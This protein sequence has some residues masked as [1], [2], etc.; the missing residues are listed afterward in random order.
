MC[1]NDE[2]RVISDKVAEFVNKQELFTSVD[3]AN[4]IKKDGTWI[5]N[6]EVAGW[7]RNFF[8]DPSYSR[9]LIPVDYGRNEAT[10]YHPG[11][12]D[13]KDYKNYDAKAISPEV[14]N[15]KY[16][17]NAVTAV[18]EEI[19]ADDT[20]DDDVPVDNNAPKVASTLINI[21]KGE[22][23]QT[24]LDRSKPLQPVIDRMMGHW[25][26]DLFTRKPGPAYADDGVFQGTD[27]DLACF[28]F[29]LVE[30][31]AVINI[32]KYK[33]RRATQHTEGQHVVSK[34]NRHGKLNGINANKETFS[35][36]I[37][38]F[39]MNVMM[40]DSVGY[41]RN[42][43]LVD[44][45]GT[46]YEGWKTLDFLP[47][48]KENDF[49]TNND[50]LSD[51]KISF[52]NFVHPNRWVSLYGQYY[53]ITKVL[54]E[55]MTDEA[56]YLKDMA[57]AMRAR[58]IIIGGGNEKKEWPQKETVGAQKSIIVKAFEAEV[59]H[60]EYSGQ[61][62][63][64]SEI[65]AFLPNYKGTTDG[66]LLKAIEDRAREFTYNLIQRLRFATRSTEYAFF[67]NGDDGNKIPAWIRN[68]NWERDIV[69]PRKK[70]KWSQLTLTDEVVI[71]YRVY[72]KSER[73]SADD[74]TD[75]G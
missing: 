61:F 48:A 52:K 30:R 45:D 15:D 58:G 64:E 34:D 53:Y 29:A 71:R 59:D 49:I 32:P 27:L 19:A 18:S 13:T 73:V 24:I 42:F 37:R 68:I 35:F 3:V 33:G 56:K 65:A 70:K 23:M 10:L 50:L 36:S 39:D 54:L 40:T 9:T 22:E 8:S 69:L 25:T 55:R 60:P 14:F 26:Y 17:D 67:T 7:L 16:K 28:L 2:S 4:A 11:F 41:H 47:S 62:P 12:A 1:T 63:E 5:R 46:W 21:F 38:I 74:E 51:N 44:V 43:M 66:E 6:R 20:M 75:D 31:G 72:D 57:S